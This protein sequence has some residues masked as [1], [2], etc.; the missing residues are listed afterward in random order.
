MRIPKPGI[1]L[2]PFR[3][4]AKVRLPD[5]PPRRG[6]VVPEVRR[7]SLRAVSKATLH[8]V[9]LLGAFALFVGVQAGTGLMVHNTV[10]AIPVLLALVLLLGVIWVAGPNKRWR[11]LLFLCIILFWPG[12]LQTFFGSSVLS[13]FVFEFLMAV[14]FS[15][16]MLVDLIAHRWKR[17]PPVSLVLLM[18]LYMSSAVISAVV[19]H[20]S[21]YH[22]PAAY[23]SKLAL[24]FALFLAAFLYF[25]RWEQLRPVLTV[26]LVA[27]IG[28]A[29]LGI[30]E[31]L[32][33]HPYY[34]YYLVMFPQN[35]DQVRRALWEH[36][37]FGPEQN[38]PAF[39]AWLAMFL[40]LAAYA[41]LYARTN[42]RRVWAIVGFCL[43]TLALFFTGTRSGAAI[44]VV[45]L[46]IL[47]WMTG[48]RRIG[49][50]MV[51]FLVLGIV[52][53]NVI[54]PR[55]AK[56]LPENNLLSRVTESGGERYST[57]L[58]TRMDAWE[59][60]LNAWRQ[61][62]KWIG[63]GLGVWV[64]RRQES[65]S[66]NT[67]AIA[68]SYS[69]YLE[70]LVDTG[71]FGIGSLVLL[72]IVCIRYDIWALRN[73]PLGTRRGLVA[74]FIVGC[75]C[76]LLCSTTEMIYTLTRFYYYF[77]LLQGLLLKAVWVSRDELA[78]VAPEP[79]MERT[80]VRTPLQPLRGLPKP[81]PIDTF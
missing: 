78:V 55:I 36:R 77:W 59:A 73:T 9:L 80:R 76:V 51:A 63:T 12:G 65:A 49:Q 74:A 66:A 56:L 6:A 54:G 64:E 50:V 42:M 28:W 2:K 11:L 25:E 46:T 62:N 20:T 43:L 29:V 41:I 21:D 24:G 79:A 44:A 15:V 67:R 4:V 17:Y 18:V 70:V 3:W 7:I 72:L 39:A 31:Y 38:P 16:F 68:S 60:T 48:H 1:L 14:L 47:P 71:I 30:L 19:N 35:I 53:V 40:P 33:P 22:T 23:L 37:V 52:Y 8:A 13:T 27:G 58:G 69:S 32:F 75:L 57:L 10:T 81:H 5:L 26:L 34:N 45:G 61:G